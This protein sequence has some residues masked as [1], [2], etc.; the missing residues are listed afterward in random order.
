MSTVRGGI[1]VGGTKM[2]AAVV[3]TRGTVVGEARRPT[4][5]SAPARTVIAELD[6]VMRDALAKAGLDSA[7]LKGVGVGW[8]GPVDQRPARSGA[9]CT[10]WGWEIGSR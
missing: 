7:A 2:Q 9:P 3:N 4:P 5:G 1:D 8:P 10:S 6:G